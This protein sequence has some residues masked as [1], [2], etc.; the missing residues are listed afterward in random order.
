MEK[1][2]WKRSVV[3]VVEF[4]NEE[5]LKFKGCEVFGGFKRMCEAKKLPY[6]TLK[7]LKFPII[8]KNYY[9]DK[10]TLKNKNYE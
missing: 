8:F 6:H 10:Q 9:I 2:K 7:V 4:E 3:V 1:S 5:I